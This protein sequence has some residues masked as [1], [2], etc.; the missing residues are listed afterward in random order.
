MNQTTKKFAG[1]TVVLVAAILTV[2]A[3]A[4]AF[5]QPTGFATGRC[6]DF[7]K[8]IEFGDGDNTYTETD[9]QDTCV[10]LRGGSDRAFDKVLDPVPPDTPMFL[11][12]DTVLGGRGKDTI[13]VL[14]DDRADYVDCG[15]NRKRDH[16]VQDTVFFDPGDVV[17]NC[18]IQNPTV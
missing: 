2:V 1:V 5:A 8:R 18:E 11:D 13:D 7:Q 10:L 16:R 3:A 14:D 4:P 12:R 17:K 9:Q 15:E 6:Q